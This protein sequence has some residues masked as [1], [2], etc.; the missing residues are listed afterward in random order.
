[1]KKDFMTLLYE[2]KTKIGWVHGIL[3][4]IG[5][6]YLSFFSMMSLS[7]I[8]KADYAIKLLPTMIITPILICFFALWLLLCSTLLC[9]LKKILYA[10]GL[11]MLSL[12]LSYLL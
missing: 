8:I 9:C 3:A 1:M 6:F 11:I 4:C 5:G 12:F 10:T 2:P 7:Y